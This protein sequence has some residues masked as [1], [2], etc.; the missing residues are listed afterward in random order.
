MTVVVY[1]LICL[2]KLLNQSLL[3]D[4]TCWQNG[5]TADTLDCD[6]LCCE[7]K[8]RCSSSPI[9]Q[10]KH[11]QLNA[12]QSSLNAEHAR[13]ESRK[14]KIVVPKMSVSE[15]LGVMDRK[16]EIE[17]QKLKNKDS[18]LEHGSE[19]IKL[20][21]PCGSKYIIWV[22]DSFNNQLFVDLSFFGIMMSCECL[23]N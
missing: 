13:Q 14:R 9:F 5:C 16:Y 23:T 18:H 22:Q 15:S 17:Y 12:G 6:I 10:E 1:T 21:L 20:C 7:V 8:S 4:F 19:I 3:A 2:S 11:S